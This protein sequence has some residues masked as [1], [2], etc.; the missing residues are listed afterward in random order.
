MF[1]ISFNSDFLYDDI[2]LTK[3]DQNTEF[4][5]H[6]VKGLLSN[7]LTLTILSCFVTPPPPLG[8]RQPIS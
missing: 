5:E 4:E 6:S 7:C 3:V 1:Q 2:E 8:L